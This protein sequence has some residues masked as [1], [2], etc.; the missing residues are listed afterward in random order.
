MKTTDSPTLGL[1]QWIVQTTSNDSW[2]AVAKKLHTTHSTIQRRLKNHEADAVVEIAR[3]Y[4]ANPI[5]GL[6]AAGIITRDDVITFAGKCAAD[7]LTDA[8]IARIIVERLEAHEAHASIP[9]APSPPGA[10]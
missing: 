3:A 8:E 10:D 9:A 1:T 2:R 5:P 6:I 7:D 4:E